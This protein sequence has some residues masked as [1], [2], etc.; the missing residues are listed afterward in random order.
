MLACFTFGFVSKI[1]GAKI[2]LDLNWNGNSTWLL[3]KFDAID[4]T[5]NKNNLL[6]AGIDYSA[7][8]F[9]G[10][11]VILIFYLFPT[12]QKCANSK[13]GSIAIVV[14]FAKN[15]LLKTNL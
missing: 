12:I 10:E 3:I 9:V 2:P 5:N 8:F 7:V 4:F 13:F 15:I 6:F 1:R 14:F 11:T